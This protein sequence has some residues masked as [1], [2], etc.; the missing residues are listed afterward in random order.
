LIRCRISQPGQQIGEMRE[1]GSHI[2]IVGD[3]EHGL[4]IVVVLGFLERESFLAQASEG[5]EHAGM[6]LGIVIEL[7]RSILQHHLRPVAAIF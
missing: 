7:A 6:S 5:V 1:K 3:V 2:W 4:G